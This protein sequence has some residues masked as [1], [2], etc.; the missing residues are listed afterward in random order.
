MCMCVSVCICAC[1][2]I[3]T[4]THMY[5]GNVMRVELLWTAEPEEGFEQE[6]ILSFRRLETLY[7]KPSSLAALCDCVY[8]KPSSLAAVP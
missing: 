1:A 8:L 2:F 4:H 6:D 7:L 3:Y 5:I